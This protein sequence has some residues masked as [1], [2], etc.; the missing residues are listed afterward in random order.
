M[1]VRREVRGIR[2]KERKGEGKARGRNIRACL[3]GWRREGVGLGGDY[4][5]VAVSHGVDSL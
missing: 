1:V 3:D 5:V 2:G 4:W